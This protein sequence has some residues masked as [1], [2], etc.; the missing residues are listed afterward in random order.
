MQYS[1]C[2]KYEC[3]FEI[4]L[5]FMMFKCPSGI[6]YYVVNFFI[7]VLLI[8]SRSSLLT[9][10]SIMEMVLLLLHL[11]GSMHHCPGIPV[12]K[13]FLCPLL[14]HVLHTLVI[15]CCPFKSR[16][17]STALM[18]I[19]AC[20]ACVLYSDNTIQNSAEVTN[21]LSKCSIKEIEKPHVDRSGGIPMTRL[22]LQVPQSIQGL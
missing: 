6:S 15:C 7:A 3:M 19:H 16:I 9:L 10:R 1:I 21:D 8:I 4:P 12:N 11:R 14:W 2:L 18:K 20:R 17:L 5:I 22:P 13:L